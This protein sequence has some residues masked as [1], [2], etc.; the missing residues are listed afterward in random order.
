MQVKKSLSNAFYDMEAFFQSNK[1]FFSG[2]V[3]EE[4]NKMNVSVTEY[5][6]IKLV[7]SVLSLQTK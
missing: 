3:P 4:V 5:Y 6:Q 1:C 2:S 7:E